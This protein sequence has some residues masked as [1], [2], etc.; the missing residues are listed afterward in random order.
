MEYLESTRFNYALELEQFVNKNDIKV[1]S[2]TQQGGLYTLFF[3][4]NLR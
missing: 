2:I 4:K 3:R 1:I